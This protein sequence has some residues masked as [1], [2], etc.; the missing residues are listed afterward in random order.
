MPKR[1]GYLY[2]SLTSWS[3]LYLA[4]KKACKHK[5]SKS[6]T[7]EWMYNCEKYLFELQA[8][9]REQRYRPQPYKYFV[10]REPKER[11]ISVASFRDRVVHHALVNIIDPYFEAI[12]IKD[13]YATRKDKGLHLAVS[14]A[15]KYA[16]RYKWYMKLDIEKYFA[17]V[18]HAILL[19]L[20]N[21]KIKD[22]TVMSLCRIILSNQTVSMGMEENKGLP[23]GNL[24]SQFFANIYLNKL[25]HFVKQSLGYQAYVRYMDD[26]ILF[27]NDPVELKQ[28]LKHIERFVQQQLELRIKPKSLQ[29]NRVTHG[30]PYLGYRIFPKLS[31]SLAA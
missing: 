25:D 6:E 7:T 9:L 12:F 4:Y 29:I 14:A 28:A 21:R 22:P 10:I 8:E 1:I 5:Q 23:V 27:S 13:S 19:N 15:Q 3:N 2:G 18:N 31:R 16:C 17:S 30:I 20:I 24:T 11:I 26:F